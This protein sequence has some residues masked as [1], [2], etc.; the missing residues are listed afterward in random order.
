MEEAKIDTDETLIALWEAGCDEIIGH[1]HIFRRQ[2]VNRDRRAIG[3]TTWRELISFTYW[4][5]LLK[6]KDESELRAL[7]CKKGV[8]I[9]DKSRKLQPKGVSRLKGEARKRGIYP[10]TGTVSKIDTCV[11]TRKPPVFRWRTPGHE[12]ELRWLNEK[13]VR[14]IHFILVEDF[15]QSPDPIIPAGVQSESLLASAV[16]RPQTALGGIL[17]YP[18]VETSATALLHSITHEHPFH[19]GNKRTALVSTLVFLD[20]NGFFP[21]FNEEQA[22]KLVMKF[23]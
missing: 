1:N 17:K 9:G 19:N 3:I 13:D 18:T 2:E 12:R 6:F 7:L 16:F 10:I 20:K 11:T 14:R 21:E 23:F 15:S 8:S 5:K 4:I 22:F